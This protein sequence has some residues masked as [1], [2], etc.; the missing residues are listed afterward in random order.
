MLAADEMMRKKAKRI[1]ERDVK[2]K[3]FQNLPLAIDQQVL[4]SYVKIIGE[5]HHLRS[6]RINNQSVK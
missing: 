6:L 4:S 5:G 1:G 3:Y 2:I